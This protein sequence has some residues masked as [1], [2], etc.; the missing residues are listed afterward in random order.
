MITLK[1][2]YEI[3]T[4]VVHYFAFQDR[5]IKIKKKIKLEAL[6]FVPGLT[7]TGSELRRENERM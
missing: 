1:G 7:K 5:A 6:I 3:L 2:D 4:A